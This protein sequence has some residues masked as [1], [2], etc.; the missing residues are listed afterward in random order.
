ME[1]NQTQQP[2][3]K[4]TSAKDFFLNLGAI[5]ALFTVVANLIDL[6][7]TAINKAFPLITDNYSYFGIIDIF[8]TWIHSILFNFRTILEF[9]RME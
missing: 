3:V 6:L 2:V 4:K 7:F 5:V 1:P 8:G 9:K